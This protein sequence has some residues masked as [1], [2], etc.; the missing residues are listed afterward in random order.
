MQ[1]NTKKKSIIRIGIFLGVSPS[2]GGMFQY[3]ET[4]IESLNQLDK[5]RYKII[6]V[7]DENSWKDILDNKIDSIKL[8]YSNCGNM[9][10]KISN[11]FQLSSYLTKKIGFL[12]P[13]IFQ[14]NKLNCDIWI[15][16]SQ[17]LHTSHIK[18]KV[19]GTIHDL[20]HRYEGAFPEVSSGFRFFLRENRYKNILRSSKIILVDSLCGKN[21]VIESYNIN[22]KSIKVLPYIR[23]RHIVNNYER[24]DFNKHYDLPKKFIFYPAQFWEH[25]NHLRLLKAIKIVSRKHSDISLVLTGAKKHNFNLVKK[26]VE[27]LGLSKHVHFKGYIQD[28]DMRG[29]YIRARAMVF[30]SFFGPTNIP[31]LEAISLNC[32]PL[33]SNIYGMSE[34]LGDCALYFDPNDHIDIANKIIEIWKDDKIYDLYQIRLNKN[35]RL[36]PESAHFENLKKIIES[37][38]I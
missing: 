3:A 9:M 18:S 36:N 19:I 5:N 34:Q 37:I 38:D 31:P 22:N 23:P 26:E 32:I 28:K 17:D 12:N 21:Q 11:F 1:K 4:I 7:Y 24:I 25:K 16:P 13:Q 27:K 33:V 10:V 35:N 8:R 29:F 6:A 30:P 20:M 14:M 2:A 15:F